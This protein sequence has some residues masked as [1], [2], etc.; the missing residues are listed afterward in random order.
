[1]AR[2]SIILVG[3]LFA[4]FGC[5]DILMEKDITLE[6]VNLVAPS[7]DSQFTSTGVF[8]TWDKIEGTTKYRLQVASPNFTSPK[9][10]VLDT[11]VSGTYF[12][13]QLAI[14]DYEWRVKAVNGG[15]ET[16]FSSRFFSVKNNDDFYKNILVLTL[17]KSNAA[18]NNATQV[19]TWQ[20]II[21]ALSYDVQVI[22]ANNKV[23]L[24]KT[25]ESNITNNEYIFLNEG[26]FTWKVRANNDKTNTQFTSR[27]LTIDKTIPEITGLESPLNAS[28]STSKETTFKWKRN[29]ALVLSKETD[30][31][32][33]FKDNLLTL[34]AYK[35]EA[36]SGH[37]HTL[38]TGTYFWTVKSFDE[39]GNVSIKVN[40]FSF[41]IQ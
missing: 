31:L 4:F 32:Y 11:L 16:P 37:T 6:K 15:Y 35:A 2:I 24:N 5:S 20:P 33:V 29:N 9:Q 41:T 27:T 23:V 38:E 7:N 34:S 26:I 40:P 10:I 21:G 18:T 8:F 39:A 14:D 13:Q 28:S 12:N 25:T 36:V 30:S 22:D 1:M 3:V 17:P 19:L